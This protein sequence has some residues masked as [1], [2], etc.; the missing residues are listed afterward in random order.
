MKHIV[1]VSIGSKKRDHRAE[2]TFLGEKF[3]LE[4]RGTD[5]DLHKAMDLIRELDGN[6]DALGMGGIDLYIWGGKRKYTF[7]QAKKMA[8]AAQKTP[9]VDGSG[10]KNT[11]ERR[12]ISQILQRQPELLQGKKVL[13][14]SAMDRFGMAESLLEAGCE[15]IYG[16]LI[17]ALGVSIPIYR[18]KTLHNIIAPVVAPIVVQLPFKLLY[19]IGDKQEKRDSNSSFKKYYEWADVIAGDFHMIKRYLPE[20]IDGKTIVTN[21]VTQGD[22]ELLRNSGIKQLIT[23]TPEIQG[24]SFGTNVIEAMII[25]LIDKPLADIMPEDYTE[26]LDELDFQPRFVALN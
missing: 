14:V 5:G 21:T 18:L 13:M 11:L 23:T 16:D 3:C 6:V 9:I 1:S 19:P 7:R 2:I 24:R 8:A 15:A 25:C 22:I 20:Y 26:V 4:R 12:V 17:F 10:L